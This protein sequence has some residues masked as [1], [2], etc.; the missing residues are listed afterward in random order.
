MKYIDENVKLL[1]ASSPNMTYLYAVL[2]DMLYYGCL[3][4]IFLLSVPLILQRLVMLNNLSQMLSM[5]GPE[6]V[7][8]FMSESRG[9]I[10]WVI[11]QAVV[12]VLAIFANYV[13]FKGLL[14]HVIT[15]GRLKG[16]RFTKSMLVNAMLVLIKFVILL[17]LAI[18]SWFAYSYLPDE[19]VIYLLVP[20]VIAYIPVMLLLLHLAGVAQSLGRM[21]K[22][23]RIAWQ[24]HK[25]LFSYAVMLIAMPVIPFILWLIGRTGFWRLFSN[26]VLLTAFFVGF[27]LYSTWV[28]FYQWQVTKSLKA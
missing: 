22:A 24:V 16:F 27:V 10:F 20:A 21:K 11:F 2:I 4:L 23:F 26:R 7:D 5:I 19:Y 18:L 13:L 17:P 3:W 25:Y 9:M 6:N 12:F 14:W 15:T 8:A 28:K 1:K